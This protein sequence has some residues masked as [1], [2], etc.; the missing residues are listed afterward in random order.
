MLQLS[1][2][3]Q[4]VFQERP[5][6]EG[7]DSREEGPVNGSETMGRTRELASKP[8]GV[9]MRGREGK[10]V[11]A[12]STKVEDVVGSDPTKICSKSAS[13]LLGRDAW[14]EHDE[15]GQQR[16][17]RQPTCLQQK[18]DFQPASEGEG[19]RGGTG[20]SPATKRPACSTPREQKE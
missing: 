7:V 18:E 14:A 19:R 5:G 17:G 15:S 8:R 3:T 6:G 16:F 1:S 12:G 13:R 4:R 2:R 20:L 10:N 11:T 9:V